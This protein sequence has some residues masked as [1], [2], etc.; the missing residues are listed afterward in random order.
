MQG[1]NKPI[2]VLTTSQ[3]KST[4]YTGSHD[5][6]VTNWKSATGENDRVQGQGHGNQ[7]NG[8]KAS[9]DIVYTA[10][11]DDTLRTIDIATNSYENTSVLRLGSQPRGLDIYGDIVI[12]ASVKQVGNSIFSL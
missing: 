2:T 7:I 6:Y 12:V 9:A 5:G 1:H 3:D 10:G 8:M 11:I 4:I